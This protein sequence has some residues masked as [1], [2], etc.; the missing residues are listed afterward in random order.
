MSGERLQDLRSSKKKEREI[1][2]LTHICPVLLFVTTI[3]V[4][5]RIYRCLASVLPVN[6]IWHC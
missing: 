4:G 2:F 1:T 5:S 6:F 3:S